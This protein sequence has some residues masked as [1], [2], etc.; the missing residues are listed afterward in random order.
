MQSSLLTINT[1][2]LDKE[3]GRQITKEE[4]LLNTRAWLEA[5]HQIWPAID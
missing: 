2:M 3:L 4:Q 5:I 1:W